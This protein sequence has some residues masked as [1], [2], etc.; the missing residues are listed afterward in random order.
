MRKQLF[1]DK[2]MEDEWEEGKS[3]MDRVWFDLQGN[4]ELKQMC[5]PIISN[6]IINYKSAS[7][8]RMAL[9]SRSS[10]YSRIF[11]S[12]FENFSLQTWQEQSHVEPQDHP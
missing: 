12:V 1:D 11:K 2:I 5:E 4:E 6:T 7:E 3:E 9:F 10:G 8:G